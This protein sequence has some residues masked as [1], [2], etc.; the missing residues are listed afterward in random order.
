MEVVLSHVCSEWR[1][2][3]INLP[4]FWTA[5]KFDT[6]LRVS[7]PVKKLEE[8]LS[9]SGTQLLE[10]YFS[11][12][13]SDYEGDP[14]LFISEVERDFPLVEAAI[15][16]ACRWRRFTFFA[17]EVN[18]S[19]DFIR[20]FDKIYVPNLEYLALCLSNCNPLGSYSA[21]TRGRSRKYQLILTGGAPR[22]CA[23]RI[24][25]VTPFYWPPPLSNITTL[26]IQHSQEG[27]QFTFHIF[28]S[29]LTIP[30]LTNLS[31]ETW[32]CLEHWT[33]DPGNLPSIKMPS[34]KTLRITQDSDIL[35]ILSRS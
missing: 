7:D 30:T 16:H 27:V 24:D 29:I 12:S 28:Y 20:L 8:Y 1:N 9:R 22:L 5:F 2:I 32:G 17:D 11:F 14:D 18:D 25:A 6:D 31:I 34:L 21:R 15:S 3:A 33:V 19:F 23:V 13:R 35:S 10:L 4:T 26:T